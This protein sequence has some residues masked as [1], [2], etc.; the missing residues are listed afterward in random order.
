MLDS[1][2]GC[3]TSAGTQTSNGVNI[4]KN[5]AKYIFAAGAT[6]FL[7]FF[8]T[9][10]YAQTFIVQTSRLHQL[11][12][13]AQSRSRQMNLQVQE[14]RAR[15]KAQNEQMLD[16]LQQNINQIINHEKRDTLEKI[17]NEMEHINLVWT[18]HFIRVLTQLDNA[19][20]KIKSRSEKVSAN[21][22]KIS[23]TTAA[24]KKAETAIAAARTAVANQVSET[25]MVDITKIPQAAPTKSSQNNLVGEFRFQFKTLRNKLFSDLT[26][27]RDGAVKDARTAVQD[28]LQVLL[29]IPNVNKEPAANS[30]TVG[31]LK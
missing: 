16:D 27:L 6:G 11:E 4:I 23:Q 19:L 17:I 15:A 24:I 31:D 9:F 8:V 29:Q 18:N 13:E 10:A 2:N 20:Q 12:L 21:G 25:Y 28:T 26:L 3:P 1:R 5:T 30:G 14:R 22:Q 7:L